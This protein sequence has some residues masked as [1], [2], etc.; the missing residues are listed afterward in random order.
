MYELQKI[1]A[2]FI[3]LEKIIQTNDYKKYKLQIQIIEDIV[4]CINSDITTD[5]KTVYV[6][7]NYKK[8]YPKE[9]GLSDF[10]I[11]DDNYKKRLEKNKE[12]SKITDDIWKII[13]KC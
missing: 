11:H 4:E 3:R 7:K 1:K 10:Y 6:T 8:L 12:L 5:E 2:L 13:K 9:G